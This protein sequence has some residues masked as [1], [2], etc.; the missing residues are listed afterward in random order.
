VLVAID[1]SRASEKAIQLVRALAPEAELILNHVIETPFEGKMRYAGVS[2]ERIAKYRV[3]VFTE[4]VQ[5]MRE[6]TA[7]MKL[8]S[9]RFSERIV[10]GELLLGSV[11]KHVINASDCDVL[12]VVDDPLDAI[13][14]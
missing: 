4:A 9:A 12:V 1:F 2:E 14:G 13:A 11:T 7:H 10:H 6:W 8:P 3:D 5:R